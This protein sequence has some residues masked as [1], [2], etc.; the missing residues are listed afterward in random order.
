MKAMVLAAGLG[1]RLRPLT[2]YW[3]KPALPVLGRP[4]IDYTMNLLEKAEIRD[5]VVN[6]HH[7]PKTITRALEYST[8]RGFQVH[9]SEEAEILG[10]AGGLKN[11]E[12]ML[13][14][15]T[16][17]L[18][19]GDTLVD[20]D[21]ADLIRFHR[22]W[23]GEA[24][25]LVRPKPTGSDYTAFGLDQNSR[26]VSVGGEPSRPLMFAGVWVLEPSVFERIPA[27]G[28]SGLEVELIPSLMK[29]MAVY[30]YAKDVAWFDIGTPR[31]YLKACLHVARR[32]LFRETW[33]VKP[34]YPGSLAL[35]GTGVSVGRQV[36][37]LGESVMGTNC[38]IGEGA[39]IQKSVLWDDVVVG[40]GAVVRN[41]II[42]NGVI[43][44]PESQTED[45]VVIKAEGDLS[46]VRNNE[47]V[48]DY[49]VA[50]IKH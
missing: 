29:D 32:G 28:F 39:K 37:F 2:V 43:L 50:P 6:L 4:I 25:M 46:R 47:Q 20:V 19:N 41:S 12:S 42:S 7:Q 48:A 45:K 30:G 23:G 10:T 14:E 9:F 44:P 16:F 38:S 49:V 24:T 40:E 27:G 33:Q 3:A 36:R 34:L 18:I 22:K 21:L 8:A 17:V 31:R 13:S 1:L 26:I 35:G 15:E 5:V 11:V